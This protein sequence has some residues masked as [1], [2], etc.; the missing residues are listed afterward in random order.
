MVLDSRGEAGDFCDVPRRDGAS[1]YHVNLAES[2]E[3]GGGDIVLA[4]KVL[5]YKS[6]SSSTAIYEDRGGD[7]LSIK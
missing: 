7:R 3:M 5:V 4:D 6:Y 1:V 2:S